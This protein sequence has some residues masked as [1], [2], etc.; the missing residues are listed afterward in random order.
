[1]TVGFTPSE[2]FKSFSQWHGQPLPMHVSVWANYLQPSLVASLEQWA[3]LKGTTN[4]QGDAFDIELGF[5][6][7]RRLPN[8]ICG[9]AGGAHVI[10]MYHTMPMMLLELC[11]T[12]MRNADVLRDVGEPAAPGHTTDFLG[13][14]GFELVTGSQK[15]GGLGEIADLFGPACPERRAAALEMYHSAMR[16]VWEHEI[17]H[18]VNGHVHYLKNHL[19]T[20]EIDESV[21][22]DSRTMSEKQ[23]ILCYLESQ[24]DAGAAFTCVVAPIRAKIIFPNFLSSDQVPGLVRQC[25]LR[26]VSIALLA[27]SWMVGDVMRADGDVRA[28]E[29]WTGHPS[30][31]VRSLSAVLRPLAQSSLVGEEI[32]YIVHQA[33]EAAT[34]DLL[35]LADL[36]PVFRPYRWLI[37]DDM[38][39]NLIADY[40]LNESKRN[41][42]NQELA[43][44]RYM[45]GR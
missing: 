32:E 17:S 10:L 15:V 26:I 41:E 44:Y 22:H 34:C 23:K 38:Y 13:V 31:L 36:S 11:Y 16:F 5:V 20:A 8:A 43:A 4:S 21:L 2:R 7:R 6:E 28:A 14:P 35:S 1:M 39:V 27:W 19:G 33:C 24:A 9:W 40:D 29:T 42:V 12:M 3:R 18:A 45:G 30:G 37:R 25:R